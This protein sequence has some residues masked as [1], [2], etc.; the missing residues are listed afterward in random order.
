MTSIFSV[1]I[2]RLCLKVT[3]ISKTC[4]KMFYR[5][6]IFSAIIKYLTRKQNVKKKNY[7]IHA[8]EPSLLE[9]SCIFFKDWHTL[10]LC[11]MQSSEKEFSIRTCETILAVDRTIID[12]CKYRN[13]LRIILFRH[14]Q[15]LQDLFWGSLNMI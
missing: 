6:I 13:V 4:F 12:G 1:D 15:F 8:M 2:V 14:E 3:Q 5:N 7:L 9:Y 10:Y 11:L